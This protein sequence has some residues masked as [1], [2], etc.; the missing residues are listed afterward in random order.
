VTLEGEVKKSSHLLTGAGV[1][2]IVIGALACKIIPQLV[3]I[4]GIIVVASMALA[5]NRHLS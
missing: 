4:A 3:V 2:L 5:G 1:A